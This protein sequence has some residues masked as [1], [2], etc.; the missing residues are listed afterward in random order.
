MALSN[1]RPWHSDILMTAWA[2]IPGWSAWEPKVVEPCNYRHIFVGSIV[3]S[4]INLYIHISSTFLPHFCFAYPLSCW[5][6]SSF[7]CLHPN[8]C[9]LRCLCHLCPYF[10]CLYISFPRFCH[11]LWPT[12][13]ARPDTERNRSKSTCP[14]LLHLITRP[15]ELW[16]WPF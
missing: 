6:C 11:F 2:V 14:F 7:A 9:C 13:L 16:G 8:S 15:G 3:L 12:F 1:A 10:S 5:W 4:Q